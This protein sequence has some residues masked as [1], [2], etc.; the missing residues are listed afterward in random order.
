[1]KFYMNIERKYGRSKTTILKQYANKISKASTLKPSRDFLLKCRKNA[2]IPKFIANSTVIC[3][4]FLNSNSMHF[5]KLNNIINE[6]QYKLL[7]VIIEDKHSQTNHSEKQLYT[8]QEEIINTFP[9]DIFHTFLKTQKSRYDNLQH[10]HKK[11]HI[12]KFNNIHNHIIQSLKLK[13]DKKSFV[14]LTNINVPTD[15][16]WFLSLGTKFALPT[17]KRNFPLFKIITDTEEAIKSIMDHKVKDIARAKIA[18]IITNHKNYQH[19][20]TRNHINQTL[21]QINNNTI[22]F[23]KKT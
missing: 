5:K 14:N 1:M 8:L 13:I 10:K 18:N 20:Q 2:V 17:D 3:S 6:F 4:K 22:Q 23:F 16:Q 11:R 21:K 9:T 15:I 19:K 7:N 12:K